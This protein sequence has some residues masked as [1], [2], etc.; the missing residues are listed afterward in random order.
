MLRITGR[1]ETVITEALRVAADLYASDAEKLST[2]PRLQEQFSR[3]AT[4]ARVLLD[5]IEKEGLC[6][7]R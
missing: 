3:Q 2:L 1:H 6:H 5:L 7:D 4:E